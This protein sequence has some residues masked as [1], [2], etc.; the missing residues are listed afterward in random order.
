MDD[1][2]STSKKVY[3]LLASSTSVPSPAFRTWTGET[4]GQPSAKTTLVLQ[5]P[6]ALRAALLPPSDLVAGE[7][8]L[9]NDIDI[10]GDIVGMLHFGAELDALRSSPRAVGRLV[11]LL[12]H[13]PTESRRK[14]AVRPNP[15]G[16]LH[17]MRR[18]SAAV[19]HH[20]DTG[21]DF[22]ELFLDPEMVYSC[23]YFL[24]PTDTLEE[25]QERKLDLICRKL[26]LQPGQRLLDV[27]C[28]WGAL[29]RYAA[30]HFGV[31][32][33]GVTLSPEQ[34]SEA[35]RRIER[36]GLQDR[37]SVEV[38]D[39]RKV[40]GDFDAVASVGMFEH[41]GRRELNTYF[42][43]LHSLLKPG[44]ILVNHTITNRSRSWKYSRKKPSFVNTYV[45][46]DGE[47]LPVEAAIRSGETAGFE[48]IDVESLRAS[49]AITLCH[50]VN[51]LE[52]NHEQAVAAADE[53]TYRIWRMYMSGSVAAFERSAISVYQVVFAKSER[54]W[55]F[56]RRWALARDDSG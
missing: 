55:T 41:V 52:Q 2:L 29:I 24:D 45:F 27:G 1:A 36:D 7:A 20:Y 30:E 19:R 3:E 5:H 53:I 33:V 22:F 43:K 6:G 18:D 31:E 25:A 35:T 38:R 32:A 14:A 8:Y 37:V 4:W 9:Y 15:R 10:E 26:Q 13:L 28:G 11:R 23:A 50:W 54:P 12:R 46:P 40:Q 16:R 51:R 21:N 44:G 39:Y 48:A 17:S 49:Y 47:L 56:G 34:A 42:A